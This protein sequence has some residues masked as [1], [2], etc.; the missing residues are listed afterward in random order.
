MVDEDDVEAFEL[1]RLLGD[2]IGHSQRLADPEA[3]LWAFVDMVTAVLMHQQLPGRPL[4]WVLLMCARRT[5]LDIERS[6]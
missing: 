4:S 6:L 3:G 1:Q 5:I 2:L